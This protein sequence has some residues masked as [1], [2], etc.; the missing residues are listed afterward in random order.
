MRVL[1]AYTKNPIS[2]HFSLYLRLIWTLHF[3]EK[4]WGF[5][6]QSEILMRN[7]GE[8]CLLLSDACKLQEPCTLTW[9]SYT[10]CGNNR[11]LKVN[12]QQLLAP[13]SNLIFHI[14]ERLHVLLVK[15]QGCYGANLVVIFI[16]VSV[17][18][19]EGLWWV[20]QTDAHHSEYL[21]EKAW[22]RVSFPISLK[23]S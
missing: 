8:R 14:E 17:L 6:L 4:G 11:Y 23:N 15:L 2:H 9:E 20:A 12:S 7:T 21:K 22:V 18:P 3:K 13:V 10:L 16:F 5:G 1:W 19:G